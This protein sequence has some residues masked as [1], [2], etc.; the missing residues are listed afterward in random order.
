MR[1]KAKQLKQFK[2]IKIT[3][4]TNQ[5]ESYVPPHAE[6]IQIELEG[7][8]LSGSNPIIGEGDADGGSWGRSFSS[9]E[10]RF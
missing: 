6:I 4:E 3:M 7:A 10:S 1:N 2:I 8:I 9:R 5:K